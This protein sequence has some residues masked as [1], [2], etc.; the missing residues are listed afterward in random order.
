MPKLEELYEQLGAFLDQP[1]SAT[2]IELAPDTP[3][4]GRWVDETTPQELTHR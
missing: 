2:N 1:Q 3:V 4:C